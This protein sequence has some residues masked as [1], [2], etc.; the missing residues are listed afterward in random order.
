MFPLADIPVYQISIDY[1]KPFQYHFVLAKELI[2]LRKKGV[3][4]I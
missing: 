1:D 4:I 3:L 2:E